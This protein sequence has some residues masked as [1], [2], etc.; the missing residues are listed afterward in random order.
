MQRYINFSIKKRDVQG[1]LLL[2]KPSGFASSF[3]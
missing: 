3:F 2:D 1:V